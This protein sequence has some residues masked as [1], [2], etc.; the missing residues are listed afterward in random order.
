[1]RTIPKLQSILHLLLLVVPPCPFAAAYRVGDV[2][3]TTVS[4]QSATSIDLLMANRPLFGIPR[5]VH[6]LRLPE[7]FSL[8]FEEGLHSLPYFD[9]QLLDQ[10]VVT[11]VYSKSGEG[12]IHSVTSRAVRS[13][14]GRPF[15][16]KQPIVVSFEWVEE[17]AVDLEAGS[18]V[19]FLATLLVS[20]IFLAQLCSVADG[21]EGNDDTQSRASSVDYVSDSQW[22]HRE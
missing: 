5:S 9:G 11:F 15:S 8:S 17:E 20:I 12:R 10:L 4:T 3:D 6:L 21:D 19:M 13:P 14:K 22:K 18:S 7:R 2:V 1:M 16:E